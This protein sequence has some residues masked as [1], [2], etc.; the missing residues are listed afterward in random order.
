MTVEGALA[1]RLG[2]GDAVVIGLG[3]MVGAGVFSAFAPA[4]AA[5][6]AGLLIGLALAE[7][8]LPFVNALGGTTLAIRYAGWN[9]VL[10]PLIVLVLAIALVA[11][12]YPAVVLSGFRPAAVLASTRAPGAAVPSTKP[13]RWV[14][15]GLPSSTVQ[16][17]PCAS[18]TSS[19]GWG[20][21]MVTW[22]MVPV[23]RDSWSSAQD[24]P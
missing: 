13:A 11:G 24:Q 8:A 2:T 17:V 3:S 10:L 4:A 16:T 14:R 18:S 12:L 6:G 5:A 7:I 22:V 23:R 19:L 1:R 15:P 9:G 21:A 20:G